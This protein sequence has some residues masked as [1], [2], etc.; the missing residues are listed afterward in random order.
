MK[1]KIQCTLI[2]E[3]EGKVTFRD[4]VAEVEGETHQDNCKQAWAAIRQ[5]QRKELDGGA[6]G[7]NTTGFKTLR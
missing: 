6:V 2:V 1:E 4:V 7:A 5:E 3:R